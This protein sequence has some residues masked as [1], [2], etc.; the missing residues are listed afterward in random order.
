M[1]WLIFAIL[2]A[3]FAGLWGFLDKLSAFQNPFTS[4]FIFYLAVIL[5]SFFLMII[6]SKKIKFSKYGL[7]AGLVVGIANIFLIY[8][9]VKN[10]LILIFPFIPMGA[11]VFF[12]ILLFT[13]KPQYNVKQKIVLS[14]GMIS[15]FIGIFIVSTGSMGISTFFNEFK[16]NWFYLLSG[17]II[18]LG[19]ALWTFFTYKSASTENVNVATYLFWNFCTGFVFAFVSFLMFNTQPSNIF[20]LSLKGYIYPAL[21]GLFNLIG[22][23]F[24]YRSFKQTNT[25]SK[26]QEIITGIIVNC[27]LIPVFFFSYFIL[28]ERVFEGF[29]GSFIVLVG[30]LVLNYA[31]KAGK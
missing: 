6:F 4:N 10:S 3:L 31:E 24:A 25:T 26:L 17:F 23:F 1:K 30:L 11:V 22:C 28:H 12:L 20:S 19:A 16:F 13:E 29:I 21:A 18:M 9:L 2:S 27:E 5:F 8:S 15:A 14:I 7:L